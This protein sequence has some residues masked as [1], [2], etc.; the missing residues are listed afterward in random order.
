MGPI[1]I[2]SGLLLAGEF[3]D[4]QRF[5]TEVQLPMVQFVQGDA[6]S[7]WAAAYQFMMD[8]TNYKPK[9]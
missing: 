7:A 2:L 6:G 3:Q 8:L 1:N 5:H 9:N 4:I